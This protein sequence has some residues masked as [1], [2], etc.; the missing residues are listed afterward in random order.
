MYPITSVSSVQHHDLSP[1]VDRVGV[2]PRCSTRVAVRYV[3]LS[4]GGGGPVGRSGIPRRRFD[5]CMAWGGAPTAR[6]TLR[7]EDRPPRRDGATNRACDKGAAPTQRGG[8]ALRRGAT[9]S[10]SDRCPKPWASVCAV[11][12]GRIK[13]T[14]PL[15][16]TARGA[17]SVRSS[18][19][20]P[21]EI[22]LRPSRRCAP[23]G[24]ASSSRHAHPPG[25]SGRSP[26]PTP[27][28]TPSTPF[29]RTVAAAAA[30]AATAAAL[31]APAAGH[32]M[33]KKPTQ[34]GLLNPN[35]NGWEVI[36]GTAATDY[37]PHCLNAGGTGSVTGANGG[38]WSPYDPT[39][40][41][42][43]AARGADHGMC[44]DPVTASPGAHA[45]GGT[46]YNGGKKVATYA[47][48]GTIDFEIAITTSHNGFMEWWVCDLDKCGE[49]DAT[50][51]CFAT[52][53]ACHKLD[54]VAHAS[55]ESGT[56]STSVASSIATPR[57]MTSASPRRETR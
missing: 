41:T 30:A 51:A 19:S 37:C 6:A 44:G 18:P 20:I 45:A 5:A 48:G 42:A 2:C 23:H 54:R 56:S 43:R 28:M 7:R 12:P 50:S 52:P 24:T 39:D 46:F 26:P 31:A 21:Q 11:L 17:P 53:G 16:P 34:R 49:K 1:P 22:L 9:R 25:R 36:D 27:N 14:P 15:A 55:C 3:G 29:R 35:I 4:K 13:L 10:E 33:M 38:A 8:I 47:A 32:G 40:A 57:S